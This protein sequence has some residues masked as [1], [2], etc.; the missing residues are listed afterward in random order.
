M[1]VRE[2]TALVV[3]RD[4]SF[5]EGMTKSQLEE[6]FVAIY[7]ARPGGAYKGKFGMIQAFSE[8]RRAIK[9]ARAFA[10]LD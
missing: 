10:D 8:L 7:H 4:D 9:R 3:D 2:A 5:F 6:I 1:T